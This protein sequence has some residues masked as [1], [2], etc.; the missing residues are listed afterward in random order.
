MLAGPEVLM[1]THLS[2]NIHAKSFDLLAFLSERV[3]EANVI[4]SHQDGA[5]ISG[6]CK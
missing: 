4:I 1:F 3:R 2:Q 5:G 6:Q